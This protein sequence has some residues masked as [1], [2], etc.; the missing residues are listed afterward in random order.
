MKIKTFMFAALAAFATLA[1]CSDD[2]NKTTGG[3]GTINPPVKPSEYEATFKSTS[4]YSTTVTIKAITENAKSQS[5]MAVVFETAFPE[6]RI[7]ILRKVSST[8]IRRNICRKEP[9]LL[10]FTMCL[11]SRGSCMVV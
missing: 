1:G 2:E 5:F 11:L 4:Y 3:G 6:L 9:L 7:M 10:I 8:I